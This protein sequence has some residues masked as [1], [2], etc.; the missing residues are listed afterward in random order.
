MRNDRFSGLPNTP[1]PPR[2]TPLKE[3]GNR[4]RDSL[5]GRLDQAARQEVT[6]EPRSLWT[7]WQ[8]S[9]KTLPWP[10]FRIWTAGKM[11][12]SESFTRW[13]MGQVFPLPAC[14][15]LWRIW[16]WFWVLP[17][18]LSVPT[19][20]PAFIEWQSTIYR[21]SP[22]SQNL[23]TKGEYQSLR[24]TNKLTDINK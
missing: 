4:D 23:E 3:H 24:A 22:P 8:T 12:G 7:E 16:I 11:L 6:S 19:T 20:Q 5:E 15:K 10:K 17:P 18:H 9:V 2:Q 21:F 13:L 1:S 14:K